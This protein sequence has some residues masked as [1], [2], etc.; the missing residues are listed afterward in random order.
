M[1]RSGNVRSELDPGRCLSNRQVGIVDCLSHGLQPKQIASLL[2][3]SYHTVVEH[4]NRA[5]H[6][7]GAHTQA[8]LVALAIWHGFVVLPPPTQDPPGPTAS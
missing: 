4:I 3:L 5:M 6:S 1:T 8:E 7:L 2:R